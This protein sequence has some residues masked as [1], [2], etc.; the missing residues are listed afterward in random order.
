MTKNPGGLNDVTQ[1]V[2]LYEGVDAVSGF[3]YKN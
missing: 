3:F 2:I 1:H